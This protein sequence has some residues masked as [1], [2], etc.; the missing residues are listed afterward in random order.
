MDFNLK[1][2]YYKFF[3]TVKYKDYKS[4]KL[5]E[6]SIKIFEEKFMTTSFINIFRNLRGSYNLLDL[7]QKPRGKSLPK[8]RRVFKK[9]YE[10]SA[11]NYVFLSFD[12]G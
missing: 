2:Y 7:A 10:I 1:K 3:D 11:S 4:N 8:S 6:K 12:F 9:Q 5:V